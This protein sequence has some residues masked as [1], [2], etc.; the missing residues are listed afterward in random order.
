MKL[1]NF[2]EIV[3]GDMV[4]DVC[5]YNQCAQGKANDLSCMLSHHIMDGKV[6][7]LELI[8]DKIMSVKVVE[9]D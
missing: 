7:G 6:V 2:L 9:D 1:K 4:I 5:Y 3:N 8:E